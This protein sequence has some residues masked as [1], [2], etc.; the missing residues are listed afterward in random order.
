MMSAVRAPQSNA[1]KTA[2]R[3]RRASISATMSSATA[4]CWPL[5]IVV[6]ERKRVLPWPRRCGTITRKPAAAR[7]GATSTKLWMS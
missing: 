1:P 3:I 4:A 5:R 7:R 6:L 2:L